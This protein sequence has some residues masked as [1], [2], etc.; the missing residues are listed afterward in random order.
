MHFLVYITYK[1]MEKLKKV[2][3]FWFTFDQF[4]INLQ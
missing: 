3:Y 2:F 4:I 1:I